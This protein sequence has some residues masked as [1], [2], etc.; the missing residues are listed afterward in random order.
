MRSVR[1]ARRK[2]GMGMFK[3][4]D[5]RGYYSG[6]WLRGLR[7]GLGVTIDMQGKFMG[8]Y[9][10][11]RR[12]GRGTLVYSNGD[13]ARGN[14]ACPK[15]R[16]RPSLIQGDEYCDGLLEGNATLKFADGSES[17]EKCRV[18]F[19]LEKS[20]FAGRY[21]GEVS[22]G[23]PHGKG[24]YTDANGMKL[25]GQFDYGLF[26]GSGTRS[27]ADVNQLGKFQEGELQGNAVVIDLTLGRLEGHFNRGVPHG[28]IS[29]T[30]TLIKGKFDGYYIDG[31]RTGFGRLNFG[32]VD[33]DE[34]DKAKQ[35]EQ[36]S[37]M[38]EHCIC[39][40]HSR[41]HCP[42]KITAQYV[43][44]RAKGVRSQKRER[45]QVCGHYL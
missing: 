33:K 16:L 25:D 36:V 7:H 44:Q 24:V 32:N 10:R 8:R 23:I 38:R 37:R 42:E 6:S 27:F 3:F 18:I 41:T 22:R 1:V 45:W 9:K 40:P 5:D 26:H 15:R 12:R 39:Q 35:L 4:P 2:H 29:S 13:L 43:S 28:H 11:E 20:F 21:D 14:Y 30:V 34:A 19:L 31:L 17:P